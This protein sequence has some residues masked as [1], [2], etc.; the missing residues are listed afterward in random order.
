M[1]RFEG[2]ISLWLRPSPLSVKKRFGDT[3]R[4]ETLRKEALGRLPN[5]SNGTLAQDTRVMLS[6]IRIHTEALRNMG[7]SCERYEDRVLKRVIN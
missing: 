2:L 4:I 1:K 5:C 7:V 3:K 6:Q